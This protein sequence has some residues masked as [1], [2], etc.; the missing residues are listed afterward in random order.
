MRA[1]PTSARWFFFQ[2]ALSSCTQGLVSRP[3]R[4]HLSSACVS[5]KLIFNM[6]FPSAC[7]RSLRWL[8]LALTDVMRE[9]DAEQD[10]N[11]KGPD[12]RLISFS[13]H[14]RCSFTSVWVGSSS[15]ISSS[16]YPGSSCSFR[17][18]SWGQLSWSRFQSRRVASFPGHTC[19][20]REFR[21]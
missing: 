11:R 1:R 16:T 18:F 2:Y 17:G 8:V 6:L 12:I 9:D 21:H 13:G 5:L 10:R 19:Q 14:H 20:E 15:A 3:C 7:V 4:I